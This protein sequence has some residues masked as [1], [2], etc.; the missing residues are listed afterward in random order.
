MLPCIMLRRK[1]EKKRN[2]QP[3]RIVISIGNK[4]RF[5]ALYLLGA[6]INTVSKLLVRDVFIESRANAQESISTG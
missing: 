6:F 1:K 5:I 4:V 3:S 2:I